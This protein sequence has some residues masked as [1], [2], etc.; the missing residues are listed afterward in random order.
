MRYSLTIVALSV[1]GLLVAVPSTARS[2]QTL[3]PTTR[4]LVAAAQKA[5]STAATGRLKL[6]VSGI[7][8]SSNQAVAIAKLVRGELGTL[9]DV[10]V[11]TGAPAACKLKGADVFVRLAQPTVVGDTASVPV[12]LWQQT[13]NAAQPIQRGDLEIQVVRHGLSWVVSGMRVKSQT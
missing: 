9:E 3:D 6:E 1:S 13:E 7:P 12:S 4:I 11:C 2:Q 5:R 10:L 8:A